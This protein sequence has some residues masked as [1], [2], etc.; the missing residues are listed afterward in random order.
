MSGGWPSFDIEKLG[1][2]GGR[3]GGRPP[4]GRPPPSPPPLKKLNPLL[5]PLPPPPGE[6]FLKYDRTTGRYDDLE[7]WEWP[8]GG[9]SHAAS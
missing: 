5:S 2:A 3:V 8:S 9:S 6:A 4:G 7:P 1:D